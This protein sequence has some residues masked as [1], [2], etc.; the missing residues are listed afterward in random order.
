[1]AVAGCLA[2]PSYAEDSVGA[3]TKQVSGE[4]AAYGDSDGVGVLTTA[5]SAKVDDPLSGWSAGGSYLVDVVSAASVDIVST[6]SSRWNQVR[7]A[8]TASAAYKPHSIGIEVSGAASSE[9][10]YLSLSGGALL[11]FD[12]D[13]KMV[14]P[15]LA[16]SYGHDTAG[17]TGTPFSVYSQPLAKQTFGAGCE[18]VLDR[19]STLSVNATFILE[20]GDQKNPYRYLP[21]FSPAVAPTIQPGASLALVDEERLPGRVSENLPQER[22]RYALAARLAR[23]LAHATLL[24]SERLYADDWGLKAVTTDLRV[25]I[26]AGPKLEIAPHLRGHVQS[27]VD[28]WKTAYTGGL[29]GGALQVPL[30]R[31]G[32][33]ELSSLSSGTVGL[34]LR[35]PVLPLTAPTSLVLGLQSDLTVTLFHDALYIRERNA[36]INV[37]QAEITF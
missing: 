20:Q 11:Q 1:M 22:R 30:Y 13:D 28:F 19:L 14:L 21:I 35:Y 24:V 36:F 25:E 2:A 7:Q 16:Y 18:F 8:G 23:R 33:R 6:A 9:P 15:S 4:V 26:D 27:S 5:V 34:S 3:I 10:D 12:L 29:S 31:T 32:D 17:R 37:L